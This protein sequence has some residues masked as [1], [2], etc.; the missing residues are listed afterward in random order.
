MFTVEPEAVF[1]SLLEGTNFSCV[2]TGTP[3][4]TI[5][6]FKDGSLLPSETGTSL[7][8]GEVSL[9]DRGFYHCTATNDQG[10][11]LTSPAILNVDNIYQYLFPVL[12]PIPSSG[13]LQGLDPAQSSQVL[14]ALASLVQGLNNQ[15]AGLEV[16]QVAPSVVLLYTIQPFGDSISPT[17]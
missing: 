16:N 17:E 13:P 15:G 2:A 6:W 14:A 7:V 10:T 3:Q 11:A 1:V 12:I 9:S 5:Q 4:P 8:F